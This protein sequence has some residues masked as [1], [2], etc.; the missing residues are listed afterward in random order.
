[1]AIATFITPSLTFTFRGGTLKYEELMAIHQPIGTSTCYSHNLHRNVMCM[2][3]VGRPLPGGLEEP[4][5]LAKTNEHIYTMLLDHLE[6]EDATCKTI[7]ISLGHAHMAIGSGTAIFQLRYKEHK[8]RI[9]DIWIKQLWKFTST[10]KSTI[11][12]LSLWVSSL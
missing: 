11:M 6:R 9:P 1:M 4:L 8:H 5:F 12:I 2:C 7:R 3:L 10:C